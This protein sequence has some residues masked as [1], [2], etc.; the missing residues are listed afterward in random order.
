MKYTTA[1][2]NEF[3]TWGHHV[4]TIEYATFQAHITTHP[5][6]H[7]TYL[8]APTLPSL[9]IAPHRHGLEWKQSRRTKVNEVSKGWGRFGQCQAFYELL[10]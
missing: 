9:W 5:T 6:R 3:E 8:K 1:A 10:R 7:S 4:S 2:Q